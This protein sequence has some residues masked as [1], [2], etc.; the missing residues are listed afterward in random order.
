MTQ[1][2][3]CGSYTITTRTAPVAVGHIHD[4]LPRRGARRAARG[5]AETGPGRAGSGERPV[6]KAVWTMDP[7]AHST[8]RRVQALGATLLGD[9]RDPERHEV[10]PSTSGRICRAREMTHRTR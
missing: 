2:G 5:L 1:I 8:C 6:G 10:S 9:A 4:P 3:G 7:R